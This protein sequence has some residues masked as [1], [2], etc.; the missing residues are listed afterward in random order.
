[1]DAIWIVSANASR[2]RAFS[3]ASPSAALEE[4]NDMV[5][6]AVRLRTAETES[7]RLGPLAAGKS[8]HNVGAAT[9]QSGYEPNQTPAEHRTEIFARDVADFLLRAYREQRYRQLVLIASPEFLGTLRTLLAPEV[10][11]AVSLEINKDY[12]HCSATQLGEHVQAAQA[13]T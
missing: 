1:M 2:A 12:T 7:D 6:D 3:Q 4:I 11:Q 10:R 5:D 8:P 9:P 13:K